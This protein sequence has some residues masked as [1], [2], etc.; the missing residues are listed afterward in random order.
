MLDT[1]PPEPSSTPERPVESLFGAW[2]GGG[3]GRGSRGGGWGGGSGRWGVSVYVG[4]AAEAEAAAR[5]GAG[6]RGVVVTPDGYHPH[7]TITWCSA[8]LQSARSR[9]IDGRSVPGRRHLRDPATDLAVLRARPGRCLRA[10]RQQS[11]ACVPGSSWWRSAN[12]FGFES[13]VS[14]GVVS[15]LG[16]SLRSP[17]GRLIEGVVQHSAALNPGNSGGPLVDAREAAWWAS[18]TAIIAIAQGIAFRHPRLDRA[19]VL[20]E[21]LTRD[22]CARLARRR[23][24][25]PA[26]RSATGAGAGGSPRRARSNAVAREPGTRRRSRIC[27]PVDL[28]VAVDDQPVG[29]RRCAASALG[30]VAPEGTLNLQ[31][32]RRTQ[33]VKHRTHC[34]RSRP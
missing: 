22:A 10:A 4:G 3:G 28:I 15:A 1:V 9:F 14:A 30:R 34:A 5:V 20:T 19:W 13:T 29:R 21:I 7:T 27:S 16:R 18:N 32:V 6:A 26:D 11:A 24:A 33:R 2:V 31:V 8:S 23:G 12:P 17:H 25:R